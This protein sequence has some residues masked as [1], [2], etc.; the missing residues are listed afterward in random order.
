MCLSNVK[1]YIPTSLGD[2]LRLMCAFA[3]TVIAS[4]LVYIVD[5]RGH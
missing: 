5:G 4:K 1:I 3:P 2:Y